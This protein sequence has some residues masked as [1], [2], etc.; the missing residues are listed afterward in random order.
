MMLPL[1]RY[2]KAMGASK[3]LTGY[4]AVSS[5]F[6]K[7]SSSRGWLSPSLYQRGPLLLVVLAVLVF[8]TYAHTLQAPFTFDDWANIEENPAIRLEQLSLEGIRR[9]AFDTIIGEVTSTHR[10]VAFVS[11]ALNYYFHQYHV[12]GYHLVNI[13]IHVLTG[14]CLYLFLKTTLGLAPLRA[15]YASR[16]WLPFLAVLIWLVHPVQI[17]A[18]TYIVQRMTSMAALFYLLSLYLY[19]RA[20]LAESVNR[21]WLLFAGCT[22]AGLLAMGCKET[23]ATLPFFLVLYEWYFFQDLSRD[24]LKRY[25]PLLL[26]VVGLLGL[27]AFVYLKGAPLATI[28]QSY[29]LYDFTPGERVMTEFRVVLFYISLLLFPHP[30]RLNLDH[31]F[32]VSHSLFDPVTTLLAAVTVAGLIGLAVYLARRERLLSFCLLWFFGNLVI[33]SSVIGLDLVFEHRNYLPSMLV[34]VLAVDLSSRYLKSIRW[35]MAVACLVVLLL[36]FWT[37]Q[38]NAVWNDNITLWR[39]AVQKSPHSPRVHNNLALALVEADRIGEGIIH[40]R[41]AIRLDPDFTLAY[42]ICG[43][44]FFLQGKYDEAIHH[45]REALR[46]KPSNIRNRNN[47]GA[48]LLEKGEYDEAIHHFREVL[49]IEPFNVKGLNNLGA[50][51]LGKGEYDQAMHYFQEALRIQPGHAPARKNLQLAMARAG[52]QEEARALVQEMPQPSG[53]PAAHYQLGNTYKAEGKLDEAMEQYQQALSLQPGF[54]PALNDLALAH[55]SRGEYDRAL[56]LYMQMIE[57]RPDDYIAYYNMACLY[58]Q[59]DQVEEAVAWLKRAVERGFSDWQLL[60]N[61][62]D[63]E[64]LRG[65]AYFKELTGPV[66]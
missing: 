11:F 2:N 19:V 10:P 57:L 41:E 16:H 65:T 18:V 37:Y 7:I 3:Q 45:F 9:A 39:D 35:G 1:Q 60:A 15:R 25:L 59:Q 66:Q 63:L 61:D 17:Q 40:C 20:R 8:L 24:W 5:R 56:P 43:K 51:L 34:S 29:S 26:G 54:L 48:A 49:R 13:L 58:A 46:I 27:V 33:E 42:G 14:I 31:D 28:M 30:S 21:K 62:E 53:D 55:M 4:G 52:N 50:A 47:L 64:N 23:S 6:H 36:S 38:R 12:F 22:L 44:A 32:P